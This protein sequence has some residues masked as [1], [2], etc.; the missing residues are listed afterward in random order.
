MEIKQRNQKTSAQDSEDGEIRESPK[1]GPASKA[2]PSNPMDEDSDNSNYSDAEPDTKETATTKKQPDTKTD[3]IPSPLRKSSGGEAKGTESPEGRGEGNTSEKTSPRV[4]PMED[5]RIESP[6]PKRRRRRTLH[7]PAFMG[8]RSVE[9]YKRLNTIDE[10]TYGVVHR[11]KDIE[12]GEV[13]ALKKIKMENCK[14]GFPITSLREINILLAIDHPNIVKLKEIVIGKGLENIYMVMEYLDHDVKMLLGQMKQPFRH[15][16]VK[17]LMRQLLS[18]VNAMHKGWILHR[19]LKTS[20]LLYSNDGIL[21]V[22][23][24]G[25]ARKYGSPIGKYTRLVV[26]LWYRAPELLLGTTTYTQAVDMWSVGCIFAEF[27]TTKALLPGKGEMDQLEK[28]FTL[29]GSPNAEEWPEYENLPHTKNFRWTKNKKSKLRQKFPKQNF[30]GGFYLDDIGFDLLSR[31]LCFNPNKRITAE[32]ALNHE[33]FNTA[34]RPQS[35]A[36]M[37]TFPSANE[38]NRRRHRKPRAESKAADGKAKNGFF[39]K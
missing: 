29:L 32:E 15:S 35:L 37:P 36:L 31:M 20:N 9:A 33:W 18:A 2:Q 34:P 4:D 30:G 19:D 17:S 23:D 13:V 27:L 7:V 25:L 3:L 26:T 21:K 39:M 38:K 28:I 22:C 6:S 8:C 24:F 5:D 16:E 1:S 12:T 14:G 10:G 11:A